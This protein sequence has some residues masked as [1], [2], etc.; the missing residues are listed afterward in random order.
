MG[1]LRD[2]FDADLVLA[3]RSKSTRKS[4]IN[5]AK[6]FVKFFMLAP[7]ALGKADVRKFLLF[8]VETRK[9]SAGYYVQLVAALKFLYR[10]TLRRPEVVASIPWPRI[11]RVRPD[12]MTRDE[13][14]RVILAARSPYWRT[15]F[16]TA[17][18]CGLRRMEVAPLRVEH[19]DSRSGLVRVVHGKGGKNREVMLDPLLLVALRRHWRS[20]RLLAPWR[21]IVRFWRTN[22][23]GPHGRPGRGR[24][25]SDPPLGYAHSGMRSPK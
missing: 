1:H 16:A 10:V 22:A 20:G 25:G 18:G 6:A 9:L 19:I 14:R 8:L 23:D 4:Y 2:R 7:D 3:G 5:R 13:V 12:V 24:S 11:P 17:Y 15:F 21:F